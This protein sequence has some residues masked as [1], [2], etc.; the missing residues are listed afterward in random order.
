MAADIF[1][2]QGQNILPYSKKMWTDLCK[3][4]FVGG[5]WYHT[6]YTP[7]LQEYLDNAVATIAVPVIL[8]FT[9]VLVSNQITR[10]GL[11]G[12]EQ[13]Y[14]NVIHCSATLLRLADDLRTS[15]DEMKRGDVPKSMQC[16]MNET[17]ASEGNAH[18]YIWHLI[19]V[20]WKKMIKDRL[21]T[22]SF[23]P[24]LIETAMNLAKMAQF[25]YLYGDGHGSQDQVTRNRILSLVVNP[26]S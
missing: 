13:E 21:K 26:I 22:Y 3:A 7:T 20:T 17:G 8:H 2:K 6:G 23:P 14:L 16:Y 18:E 12:F 9:Y 11:E 24:T 4:Y 10:E 25:M 5:K 19:D 15:T 1:R